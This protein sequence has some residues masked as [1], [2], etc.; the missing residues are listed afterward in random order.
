MN[1]PTLLIIFATV[2]V[3]CQGKANYDDFKVYKVTPL[4][5]VQ[6]SLLRDLEE[7]FSYSFWTEV[8][9]PNK[10]VHIMVP[11]K[12]IEN[13]NGFL[14]NNSYKYEIFINNVQERINQERS[15]VKSNRFD[16]QNYHSLEV[17]YDY[18]EELADA[19]PENVK[20]LQGGESYEKRKILGVHI[21]YSKENENRSVFI[22]GGIHARE[23]ISPSTVMYITEQV[24]KS[25]DPKVRH[26]AESHDWYIFP[27][28]NPDGYEYTHTNVSV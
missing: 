25:D 27:V 2:L 22:E 9:S 1:V 14:R 18:L 10:P 4:T 13:F 21:S 28:F 3:N 12:L 23:W 20:I 16:F 15:K 6:V 8:V 19:F 17:I 26:V 24:L 11:P 5:E 7:N